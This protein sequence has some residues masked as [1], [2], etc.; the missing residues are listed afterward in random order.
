MKER[1]KYSVDDARIPT[2]TERL[3]VVIDHRGGVTPAAKQ[4]GISRPTVS[5]W[6]SGQ[7]T[8]DAEG[9]KTIAE[10]FDISVDW[11]LN[12]GR[13]IWDT[14]ADMILRGLAE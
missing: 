1:K 14:E 13:S 4:L 12:T 9:L 8:P 11:L 6:Y 5:F 3:R 10:R 7:R 2:L